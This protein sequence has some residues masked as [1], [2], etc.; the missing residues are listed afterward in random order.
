VR[1]GSAHGEL[2]Q[3]LEC[4]AEVGAG[5]SEEDLA[6]LCV[7]SIDWD[8]VMAGGMAPPEEDG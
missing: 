4:C 1:A 7:V 3:C 6:A 5:W 8:E 2:C